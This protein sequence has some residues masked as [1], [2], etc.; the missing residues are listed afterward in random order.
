MRSIRAGGK[1]DPGI[2]IEIF[3]TRL[4][5]RPTQDE[6]DEVLAAYVPQL[7]QEL[8]APNSVRL[9]PAILE[10]LDYLAQRSEVRLG[11]ATGNLQAGARAKLQRV[12]LWSR[13]ADG[14]FGDDSAQRHLLV[15]RAIERNSA[16]AQHAFSPNNVVIVGDTVRD[17][18]A[19][20]ACNAR[21]VAVAT[22]ATD[23]PSLQA[24]KPDAAFATLSELPDWHERQNFS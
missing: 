20:R 23:L 18:A 2:V 9:M 15:Q 12:D 14:G 1:T 10:T 19:A 8:Q 7:K 11:I 17:I 4:Q 22:G 16:A 21:V 24:A 3:E 5:R 6:I 13:F